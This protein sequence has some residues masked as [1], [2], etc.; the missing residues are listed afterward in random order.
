MGGNIV[1][2]YGGL[3]LGDLD[4]PTRVSVVSGTPVSTAVAM[5][6]AANQSGAVVTSGDSVIGVFTERD[7]TTRVASAPD[8]WHRPID[9]FMTPEPHVISPDGTAVDALRTLNEHVIRNLPVVGP[10]GFVATVTYYDLIRVASAYLRTHADSGHDITPE[11]SLEYID[12]SGIDAR[13]PLLAEPSEPVSS[14]IERM[15]AAGTGLVTVVDGRGVVVGE[16][17]EHDV[18]T[19]LACQVGDLDDQVIGDWMT[20]EIAGT[21]STTS[22][23]AGL[24]LMAEVGHRYL[25][26]LNENRH[27]LGVL[28]FREIAEY[29]EAALQVH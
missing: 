9:E 11:A 17:T 12:L 23:A 3:R 1:T 2:Y 26:L 24:H 13:E 16:F 21:L 15:I 28:T 22:I 25:V 14:A 20:E 19:K 8:R 27:A 5:M 10:S 6:A 7:V 29:F 4:L 18:L